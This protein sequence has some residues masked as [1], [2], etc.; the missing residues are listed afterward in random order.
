MKKT[1]KTKWGNI[2]GNPTNDETMREIM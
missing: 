1:D 2:I